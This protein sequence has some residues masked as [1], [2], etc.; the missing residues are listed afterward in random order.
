M[1]YAC[2]WVGG[3]LGGKALSASALQCE[4]KCES[5]LFKICRTSHL[6]PAS[7]QKKCFYSQLSKDLL[8]FLIYSL[9]FFF[10]CSK[11]P[12]L[13]CLLDTW[14]F[15]MNYL[16]QLSANPVRLGAVFSPVKRQQHQDSGPWPSNSEGFF[17]VT[18][19]LSLTPLSFFFHFRTPTHS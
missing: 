9:S 15:C 4:S 7:V 14:Y 2:Q 12:L 6:F 19:C 3:E 8:T 5:Q 16:T 18:L 17:P 1:S 11:L 10:F 13:I